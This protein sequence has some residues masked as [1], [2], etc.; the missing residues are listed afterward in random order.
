MNKQIKPSKESIALKE[1]EARIMDKVK[2]RIE[3]LRK[4]PILKQQME[5]ELRKEQSH[6]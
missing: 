3:E 5:D 6:A 1:T 2:K 4:D